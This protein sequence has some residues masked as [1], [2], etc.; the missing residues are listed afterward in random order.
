MCSQNAEMSLSETGSVVVKRINSPLGNEA[1]ATFSFSK[2][3]G[4]FKSV[5]S[6]MCI[7]YPL[8]DT[9][10]IRNRLK[11]AKTGSHRRFSFI[12]LVL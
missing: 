11:H 12:H 7:K 9:Y 4:H 2:G 5:Q 1:K 6:S 3:K 10:Y 8:G